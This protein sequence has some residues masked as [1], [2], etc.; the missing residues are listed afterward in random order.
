MSM[1][2][3]VRL[4]YTGERRIGWYEKPYHSGVAIISKDDWLGYRWDKGNCCYHDGYTCGACFLQ[5]FVGGFSNVDST[6]FEDWDDGLPIEESWE[7]EE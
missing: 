7:S 3:K 4:C 2:D 5:H 1:S 6:W